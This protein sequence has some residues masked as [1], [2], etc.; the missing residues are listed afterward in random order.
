MRCVIAA[1]LLVPL[2][3][4]ISRAD[5]Y[6]VNG[7][8]DVEHYRFAINLSEETDRI[9]GRA[10]IRA[11]IARGDE[12]RIRLDLVQRSAAHEDR[13]MVV[14]GVTCAGQAVDFEHVGDSLYVSLPAGRADNAQVDIAIDY[15]GHP[16][17]GLII[18]DNKH[19]DRTWFSD[20]WPNKA[21]HWL[22]TVD[23]I[24]DKATSEFIVTAPQRVQVVSNGLLLEQS[25]AGDGKRV[26]H[27]RQSVPISPWLYVLGAAEFAVQFVDEFDGK[28]IQTWV[29]RQDREHGFYDFAVPTRAALEFYSSYVGP[30]EYE[31]LANIQSNSVGG[32]MEAA[33]AILYGDDS[34]TGQRT[35]RWQTVIVHEVAHQWFGN[36]V[37]EASWDDV[38]L[39][40]GFA[41]YFAFLFF[42]H[43]YGKEVFNSKM[44]GAKD[45][46]LEFHIEQPDYRIVHENLDDMSKVT[47]RQTYNKG[48]WVLHMLRHKL[49][50][51]RWWRGIQAYYRKY[52]NALATTVQFRREMEQVC[53]CS[54]DAF[55]EQWLYRGGIPVLDGSWSYE[56]E[57][58]TVAIRLDQVQ[59]DSYLFDLDIDIGVYEAGGQAPV[60]HR[61]RMKGRAAGMTISVTEKPARVVLD[62]QHVLLAQGELKEISQ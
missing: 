37:T 13:G 12:R 1:I 35:D 2:Y 61:L 43:A 44:L 38:W 60:I 42:E 20:N 53:Q 57:D 51:E 46:V 50:D 33:S 40:E 25:G 39:S 19:G 18:G 30:F 6:P 34:V 41:T 7:N 49:G 58:N 15:S 56:A 52:R 16:V 24:A 22:P 48:A 32:G 21:R 3:M 27:W 11:R 31:K 47:S 62:P 28:S 26:T 55:F 45:R 10:S 59:D 8:V 29:Y 36:S 23:H 14:H 9:E 4:E 54:L 17:T 5:P